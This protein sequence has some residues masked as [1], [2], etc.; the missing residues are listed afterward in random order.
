MSKPRERTE[1]LREWAD[2]LTPAPI[3]VFFVQ[4][5]DEE[6]VHAIGWYMRMTR[7]SAPEL[8]GHSA[9]AAEA[10][11]RRLREQQ[12]P[13]KAQRLKPK[14]KTPRSGQHA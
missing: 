14:S 7:D 3:A 12:Q 6:E 13:P 8:L 10:T 1:R 11:L 4:K 9:G 5:P 2:K